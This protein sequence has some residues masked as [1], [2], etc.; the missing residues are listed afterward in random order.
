MGG[1][2][3]A[4]GRCDGGWLGAGLGEEAFMGYRTVTRVGGIRV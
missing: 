3:A 4:C 1:G 2:G